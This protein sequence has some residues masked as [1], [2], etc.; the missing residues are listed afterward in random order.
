MKTWLAILLL[1]WAVLAEADTWRF[2]LIGDTPYSDRERREFPHMLDVIGNA[3]VDFVAHIGDMKGGRARCDDSLFEDRKALFDASRVPFIFVPGDN[4]WTDCKR[5]SNGAYD[6][7]ERLDKLRGLFWSDNQSLGQ[8]RINLDQQSAAYPEH[9]RFR[10]GP[11]L[12]V[13][14]NVPG[15][16]NDWGWGEKPSAEFLARNPLVLAWLKASFA[17]AR[18]EKLS[19]VVVLMQADP[20]FGHF[21]QG[22]GHHGFRD[23][24]NTLRK[25]TLNFPGEVVLMHGDTHHQQIDHPLRDAA[26]RTISRFTRVES[27]GSPFM[28]WVEAWIDTDSPSLFHFEPHP[29]P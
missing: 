11:V 28:G 9:A 18:R 26:G 15:S 7:L 14:L 29:W 21:A 2:A 12:F 23:L 10:L 27:Y 13:T 3:G 8:R 24:L 4:E 25:E 5:I 20:D 22:L 1:G 17:L 6:P 19:G 16:D